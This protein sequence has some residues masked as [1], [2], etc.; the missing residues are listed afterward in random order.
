M[1]SGWQRWRIQRGPV[2]DRASSKLDAW[3]YAAALD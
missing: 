1:F 2:H 3:S